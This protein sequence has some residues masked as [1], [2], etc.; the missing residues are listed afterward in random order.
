MVPR[1][2]EAAPRRGPIRMLPALRRP[3]P[4]RR[5][6]KPSVRRRPGLRRPERRPLAPMQ[7]VPKL[8]ARK[9]LVP[10]PLVPKPPAHRLPVS[11]PPQQLPT[12]HGK[13]PIRSRAPTP[14]KTGRCRSD[15]SLVPRMPV[16]PKPAPAASGCGPTAKPFKQPRASVYAFVRVR[17]PL[18]PRPK[19]RAAGCSPQGWT[20]R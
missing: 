2:R 15:N 17:L 14:A 4:T 12:P 9:P 11:R 6:P 13:A 8:R 1:N 10:K 19:R 20:P 5:A 7:R 3:N 16:R 18:A